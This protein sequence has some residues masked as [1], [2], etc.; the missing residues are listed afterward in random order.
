MD[1]RQA[2]RAPLKCSKTHVYIHL[3][4]YDEIERKHIVPKVVFTVK[5]NSP[6]GFVSNLL[7]IFFSLL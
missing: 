2:K 5:S 1:D 4:S 3:D 6:N 7:T